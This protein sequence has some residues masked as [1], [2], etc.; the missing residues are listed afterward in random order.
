MLICNRKIIFDH[1]CYR[2]FS[3]CMFQNTSF[4]FINTKSC[5]KIWLCL[6][7]QQHVL[8]RYDQHIMVLIRFWIKQGKVS[9]NVLF[10]KNYNFVRFYF[11][12]ERCHLQSEVKRNYVMAP[13]MALKVAPK[14]KLLTSSTIPYLPKTRLGSLLITSK[15]PLVY[16]CTYIHKSGH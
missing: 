14:N 6:R 2:Y 7:N 9:Y 8:D 15:L 16:M 5:S 13:K 4:V 10:M 12:K 11:G 3:A 1:F